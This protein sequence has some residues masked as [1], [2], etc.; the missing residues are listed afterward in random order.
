MFWVSFDAFWFPTFKGKLLSICCFATLFWLK[1]PLKLKIIQ[2]SLRNKRCLQ[3]GPQKD[4]NINW[5]KTDKLGMYD[6]ISWRH[7]TQNIIKNQKLYPQQSQ[8]TLFTLPWDMYP[9]SL[10]LPFYDNIAIFGKNDRRN[11]DI[12]K[13]DKSAYLHI[14][15]SQRGF[16]CQICQ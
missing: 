6:P 12:C 13:A 8:I 1:W 10:I 4:Q 5:I 11:F 15:N 14:S 3:I 7:R 9:V 16:W 2:N